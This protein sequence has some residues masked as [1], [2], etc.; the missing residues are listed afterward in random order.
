MLCPQPLPPPGAAAPPRRQHP[1][2]TRQGPWHCRQAP[3]RAQPQQSGASLRFLTSS[4]GPTWTGR[5]AGG[6]D[7]G[8][9]AAAVGGVS[10]A[11]D[12]GR[13][14]QQGAAQPGTQVAT[15]SAQATLHAHLQLWC[16]LHCRPA[17]RCLHIACCLCCQG[18]SALCCCQLA[19]CLPACH[20]SR[21][22]PLLAAPA[23]AKPPKDRLTHRP[24]MRP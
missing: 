6:V 12:Q 1:V 22:L 24:V 8:A 18:G 5:S 13:H 21:R 15:P 3:W 11:A 17:C 16:W 23:T 14:V 7:S 9:G 2:R 20:N 4:A 10:R 19:G